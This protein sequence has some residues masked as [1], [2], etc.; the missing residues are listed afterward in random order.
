MSI[1]SPNCVPN[2]AA[3]VPPRFDGR[4]P[5]PT[6]SASGSAPQV[7]RTLRLNPLKAEAA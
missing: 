2:I 6:G 7:P 4:F 5:A 1:R 3:A